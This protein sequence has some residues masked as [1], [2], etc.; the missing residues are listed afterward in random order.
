[1]I[2]VFKTLGCF[3]I[4]SDIDAFRARLQRVSEIVSPIYLTKRLCDLRAQSYM[5]F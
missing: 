3:F 2:Q 5:T 1:M 4:E